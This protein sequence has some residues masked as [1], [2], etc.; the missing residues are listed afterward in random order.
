MSTRPLREPCLLPNREQK[1]QLNTHSCESAKCERTFASSHVH[2]CSRACVERWGSDREHAHRAREGAKSTC[3]NNVANCRTAGNGMTDT[4]TA[5]P[6]GGGALPVLSASML[7]PSEFEQTLAC[8]RNAWRRGASSII[9]SGNP[10]LVSRL[11]SAQVASSRPS[12]AAAADPA[13]CEASSVPSPSSATC[14]PLSAS[15]DATS[16]RL[17]C[18]WRSVLSSSAVNGACTGPGGALVED[19]FLSL[20]PGVADVSNARAVISTVRVVSLAI[21]SESLSHHPIAARTPRNCAE[22]RGAAFSGGT[23]RRRRCVRVGRVRR[24][25]GAIARRRV[26]VGRVRNGF[27]ADEAQHQ[28]RATREG[29]VRV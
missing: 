4:F 26:L 22:S 7:L 14:G 24:A 8:S 13:E 19:A 15:S 2:S 28:L 1:K 25:R 29:G 23:S 3:R 21:G 10:A 6:G 5:V 27:R 17:T 12:L 9:A 20:G 16:A 11:P 18:R